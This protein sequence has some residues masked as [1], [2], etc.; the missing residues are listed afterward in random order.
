MKFH[1]TRLLKHQRRFDKYSSNMVLTLLTIFAS[2]IADEP[3]SFTLIENETG[4]KYA[5]WLEKETTLMVYDL[6]HLK[7]EVRPEWGI[8]TPDFDPAVLVHLSKSRFR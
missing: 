2:S 7:Y 6:N 5:F 1:L 4:K 8:M 3:Q